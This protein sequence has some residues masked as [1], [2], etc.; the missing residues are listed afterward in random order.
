MAYAKKA[1]KSNEEFQT[2]KNDIAGGTP[3][4]AYLF[5]GEESY[6][7]E[8]YLGE[9]RRLLVPAGF[10]EFNY[11]RLEG[12]DLTV[13]ALV[14]MAEAM[15]MMA[16]R[17]LLVV[18]DFDL[19][20]LPEEQREKLIAFLEDVPSYCCVIFVYDTVA[21]KPNRTLKKLCK[22]IADRVQTVE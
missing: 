12:R 13:Q 5:Y 3:G 22:A 15:P 20:K 11:H 6:L 1:P 9:L 4:C 18:T 14:E 17:T 7:R 16:E 8:Y 21:Y 10:E 19:F 2:L